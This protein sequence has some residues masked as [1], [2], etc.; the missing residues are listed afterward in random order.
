MTQYQHLF[1]PLKINRLTYRN[2]IVAAPM[3][4]GLMYQRGDESTAEQYRSIEERARGGAA[5]VQVGEVSVNGTDAERISTYTAVDF[6]RYRGADFEAMKKYS[7]LI[8]KH[9]AVALIEL[10]HAGCAKN[11]LPGHPNPRGPMGY[12]RKDGV[13][14]DRMDEEMI[15]KACEDFA[16]AAAF[17]QA[18]GFDGVLVHAGHGWLFSQFLSP[19][20]NTRSDKYGGSLENRARFP[21]EIF[22]RIRTRVGP[23]FIIEARINGS[24]NVPGGMQADDTGRFCAMIEGIV[25]SVHITAGLYMNPVATHQFSSMFAPHACNAAFSAIVK[26]YTSMPV[27]VVGGINS[28]EIAEKIIA[29]GQADYVVLARQLIAD[30]EFPLKS[31]S[32]RAG[33]IRRCLR[34]F[35]CFPGSTQAGYSS[36]EVHANKRPDMGNCSIN[37]RANHL[38]RLQSMPKPSG[39]RKVL[40]VGGGVAGLQAAITCAE[41][42]HR[43][44]LV[45]KEASLG[46]ILNFT[47]RDVDKEDLRNFK[48]LL[49]IETKLRGVE[50]VLNTE[51]NAVLIKISQPDEIILATG[52]SPV[53]TNIPGIENAIPALRVYDSNIRIGRRVLVVGGGL[54]GCEVGLHLA[55]TGHQVT[56]IEMLKRLANESYG[57]YWEALMAEMIKFKVTGRT[58]LRCLE[59]RP[60]GAVVESPGVPP[61]LIP[62]DSLIYALGMRPND[63]SALEAAAGSVP[64]HKIGDCLQVANVAK[65]V[66]DACLAAMRII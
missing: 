29:G 61:E 32:S 64:V 60:E 18:A 56:I 43:V 8:K 9:G 57:M 4:M 44:T 54:V 22:K 58:G 62:A 30:P 50:V 39:V 45:E 41:R 52:S 11:P 42:G 59:I 15:D 24:D 48:D 55:K 35:T 65:A 28:P 38:V 53:K 47:N 36:P 7:E 2:R 20:T 13:V 51:V 25:D 19:L 12:V 34:C 63:C 37:P 3:L 17:M 66:A 26:Q 5:A 40:I 21:I 33:E 31:M 49:I 14:I 16:V 27:G 46:G 23:G 10:F 1:Q 6:T